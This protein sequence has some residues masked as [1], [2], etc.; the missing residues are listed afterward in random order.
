MSGITVRVLLSAA[1]A[2]SMVLAGTAGARANDDRWDRD[3]RDHRFIDEKRWAH[4]RWEHRH[5]V[6]DYR[7]RPV[8]TRY[9]EAPPRIVQ[10]PPVYVVPAPVYQAPVYQAPAYVPP[11][12]PSLNLN[13]TIPLH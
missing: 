12:A 6:P 4:E 3:H 9:V 10:Q 11:A 5:D 13:F 1:L 2:G 7:Y 8:A